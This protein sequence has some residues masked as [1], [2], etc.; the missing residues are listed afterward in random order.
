MPQHLFR[1][2][3]TK[4]V[5]KSGAPHAVILNCRNQ[6]RHGNREKKRK[7]NVKMRKVQSTESLFVED[8]SLLKKVQNEIENRVARAQSMKQL[9]TLPMIVTKEQIERNKERN[10]KACKMFKNRQMFGRKYDSG[11]LRYWN[12]S[13]D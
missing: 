1:V 4:H 5:P 6:M 13:S 10:N 11:A 9:I 2:Q 8:I 12:P 7:R 3:V